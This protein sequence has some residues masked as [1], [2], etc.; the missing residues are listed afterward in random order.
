[1]E[2]L[3]PTTDL[4]RTFMS[5]GLRPGPGPPSEIGGVVTGR[6]L[7]A[8]APGRLPEEIPPAVGVG[9]NPKI[10][11]AVGR[12]SNHVRPRSWTVT[13]GQVGRVREQAFRA[14]RD[15]EPRTSKLAVREPNGGTDVS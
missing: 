2:W 15:R 8:R 4:P 9:W 14:S 1:V 11:R 7:L 10:G 12:A 3:P 5:A 6:D 13:S